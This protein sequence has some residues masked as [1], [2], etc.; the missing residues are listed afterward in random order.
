MNLSEDLSVDKEQLT[1]VNEG[2]TPTSNNRN[3]KSIMIFIMLLEVIALYVE[4]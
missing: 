1:G 3:E 2:K 4:N